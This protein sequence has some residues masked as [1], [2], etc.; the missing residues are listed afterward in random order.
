MRQFTGV[1]SF[2]NL[3]ILRNRYVEPSFSPSAFFPAIGLN[4]SQ[5][6]LVATH[7]ATRYKVETDP[8]FP[9]DIGGLA[10]RSM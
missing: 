6:R 3:P 7:S 4:S 9:V 1:N 5:D 2:C 8:A 10:P